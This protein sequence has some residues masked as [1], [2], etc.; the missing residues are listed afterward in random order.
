[1]LQLRALVVIFNVVLMSCVYEIS[2]AESFGLRLWIAAEVLV[3]KKRTKS[4]K[5]QRYKKRSRT[6]SD[7]SGSLSDID[8][9]E[10]Y[11]FLFHMHY[12]L[13]SGNGSH[14]CFFM[15]VSYFLLSMRIPLLLFE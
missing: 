11:A 6:K 4:G 8:D 12:R 5:K 7:G 3:N 2:Y 13:N 1:M 9:S 10:A 14:K 15:M